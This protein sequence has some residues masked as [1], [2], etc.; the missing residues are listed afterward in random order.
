MN[1]GRTVFS[2]LIAY[3]SHNDFQKCV[4]RYNGDRHHRS[5]SCWDQYLAMGFAQLTYRES[6]RDIEACLRSLGG[7][8]YHMGFRSKVP[9]STLADANETHDW[10]IFADYAQ[11]LIGI[12]RPL[13]AADPIGLE[14]DH[15]LYALDST[16]IDLCLSLFPWAK[17]R[18][19]KAAVKMHTLLDLRGHIPTFI[20]ITDGKVHDVNI[21]DEILPE[22]GA[23]YV[24]DRGY[25]DFERLYVLTLCSA[26]FVVRTKE[27]VLLERR[28]SHPVDKSSG[29]QSDQTVILTAIESA[30]VYPDA[31]RRVSFYDVET[32]KR[33][34]FLTNNFVLPALTIAQIYKSRWQVELFFKWIKQHLRIKAF[35][36][37]SE[38][39]VKTQ[40]WIAVSV[41]VL[42]AIIRKRLGLEASLYQILQILSLTLFEKV[43][44]LQALQPSD[45]QNELDENC[46]QLILFDF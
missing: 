2:Q 33:L 7:K 19:H 12:A 14:L 22:A 36:G 9:R 34:K 10:R 44:I 45:C 31:L 40:I 25:I 37:T 41:Y 20:R 28:Y 43:S 38:N 13:H 18:Q 15:T 3:L 30:K 5:L 29:V 39:A 32:A 42:V 11:H 1:A 17:F 23:F 35:F 8:L 6:L 16:T 27:N 46:N 24:M 4:A 21:L 26:F